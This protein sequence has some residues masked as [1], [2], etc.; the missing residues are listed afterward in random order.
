MMT[1]DLLRDTTKLLAQ[2]PRAITMQK[3][4]VEADLKPSW[5]SAFARNKIPNPGVVFVQRL[6]DY[7]VTVVPQ[8]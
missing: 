8:A 5:L 6:F 1:E 2:V 7:L 3:I 4:A